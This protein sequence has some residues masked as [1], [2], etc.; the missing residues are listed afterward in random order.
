MV[1]RKITCVTVILLVLADGSKFP[2]CVILNHKKVP[3]EQLHRV[4]VVGCQRKFGWKDWL[5]EVWNRGPGD[6]SL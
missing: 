3:K 5:L 1:K 6:A 4:S 2:P